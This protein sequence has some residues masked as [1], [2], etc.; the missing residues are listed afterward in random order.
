VAQLPIGQEA[1]LL[2]MVGGWALVKV[3]NDRGWVRASA[4]EMPGAQ[5][6]AAAMAETG[7]RASGNSAVPLGVRALPPRSNRHA[8]IIAIGEYKKD[9]SR[10]VDSLQGVKHDVGSA[11]QMARY[12]QVPAE[13]I[14]LLRDAAATRAGV[15]KAL[16]E[17]QARVQPGD[18]L[19]VYWSGH[20]SRYFDAAAGGCVET[21]VPYDLQ[22]INNRQFADWL[23]PLGDK[24][25]K[26]LVMYD[27][28]HSGTSKNQSALSRSLG[29]QWKPKFSG[30]SDEC[31]RPSNVRDRGLQAAVL[32]VGLAGGD[33]VH[34]ASSRP[35]E[36]SFDNA[37]TGG[38]ATQA[39]RRCLLEQATK[40]SGLPVSAEQLAA[41]AQSKVDAQFQGV[42]N[43]SA[44]NIT[45]SGNRE[46]V[47]A[48]FANA[49]TGVEPMTT[50]NQ[51][52]QPPAA[53]VSPRLDQVMPT[54]APL[55]STVTSASTS[56]PTVP[57][58]GVLGQIHAQRDTKRR[59][60]VTT[61]SDQLKIGVDSLDFALTSNE[62]GYVYVAM[63]G[64]DKRSLY[65]LFP[66]ELDQANRIE[67]NTTM[68]LP[69]DKWRIQASG[70]AGTDQLLVMV[71]DG[72]RDLSS[73]RGGRAGPFSKP[74]TDTQ[75]LAQLQWLLGTSTSSNASCG[76]DSQSKAGAGCSDAFGSALITLHER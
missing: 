76:V 43:V 35:D 8:L 17:L 74:L 67:R 68:L 61:T 63:L 64:S 21:L 19:F 39:L 20:G 10:P 24:A 52:R 73:L 44:P 7:R 11:L 62:P 60:G 66:N 14:T 53:A 6:G 2:Q 45:L 75:G 50:G 57:L 13:N 46:F 32:A 26:M 59:V 1:E 5:A 41:C 18:R 58:E 12:F 37:E 71:S 16:Q 22:D 65:L 72:P 36:I 51:G 15:E 49:A 54:T 25:D 55:A 40:V 38:L 42:P 27:A 23:K 69:R 3:N 29:T 30:A 34:I 28:C 31:Q 56:L 47:P 70:P 4:L 48:W 9:A 33:V